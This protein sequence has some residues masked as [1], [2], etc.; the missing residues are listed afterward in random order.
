MVVKTPILSFPAL[1]L[2]LRTIPP[3]QNASKL[4]AKKNYIPVL[5]KN[6]INQAPKIF[7]K[8]YPSWYLSG[9][10]FLDRILSSLLD[11]RS[12]LFFL[13]QGLRGRELAS[14]ADPLAI[15]VEPHWDRDHQ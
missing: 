11:L 6:I 7:Q 8:T 1:H 10:C 4:H 13:W 9:C 12:R 15:I 3:T 14:S 5:L 2:C